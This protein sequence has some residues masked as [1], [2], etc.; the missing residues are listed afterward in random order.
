MLAWNPYATA[1]TR[2]LIHSDRVGHDVR[3]VRARRYRARVC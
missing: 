1:E 2:K 3:R